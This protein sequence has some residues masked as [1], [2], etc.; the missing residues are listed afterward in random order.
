MLYLSKVFQAAIIVLILKSFGRKTAWLK[1]IWKYF[2]KTISAKNS[3][4]P[5]LYRFY[6]F[7]LS[8]ESKF[9]SR[10]LLT[11]LFLWEFY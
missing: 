1:F 8:F 6:F 10:D 2:K 9:V 5:S 4:K 11:K 3:T 7:L